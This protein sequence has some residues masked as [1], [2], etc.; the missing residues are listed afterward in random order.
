MKNFN[1]LSLDGG[2]AWALLQ[3]LALIDLFGETAKGHDVLKQYDLVAANSGGAL[4]LGGLAV[5]MPLRTLLDI[6]A[7]KNKN[8]R[9]KIFVPLTSYSD[10]I[11]FFASNF[12]IGPKY[13]THA[14]L[15]GLKSI[16]GPSGEQALSD[17][18]ESIGPGKAGRKP[19]FVICAFDYDLNREIFFRSDTQSRS[20]SFTPPREATLVQAVHASSTAPV[21]Y[22]DSPAAFGGNRYWD[23]AIGGY[24]NPVLAAVTEAV[25]NAARYGTSPSKIKALSLGTGSVVLPLERHVPNEDPALVSHRADPGLANDLRKLATS[26]LDDPP[27]AA[28]FHAHVSLGG[29]M[30]PDPGH[31]VV[32]GPVVRM[33]PLVQPFKGTDEV[34]WILPEGLSASQFAG[35]RKLGMDAVEQDQ[36]KLI[37]ALGQAWLDN[38]VHNQ[39]IRVNHDTLNVEIGDRWYR[40]ARAHAKKLGLI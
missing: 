29:S 15:A 9:R 19:Q 26:I 33:N 22:F 35:L 25:A 38:K 40:D 8:Q 12:G 20:G 5:N 21:N 36:V 11:T 31:P 1:I 3:V 39:P 24:N 27:D 13:D 7:D 10:L 16:L 2:G 17:L 32:G 34:P 23:G 18:P 37:K 14:K 30:P 4:V 28:S 6:F